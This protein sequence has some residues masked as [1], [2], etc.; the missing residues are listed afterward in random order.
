MH[1]GVAVR[2]NEQTCE[3]NERQPEQL[4]QP[5]ADIGHEC[6]AVLPEPGTAVHAPTR[7]RDWVC[8]GPSGRGW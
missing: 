5:C 1:K 4:R 3:N 8:E 6:G 2:K 7:E